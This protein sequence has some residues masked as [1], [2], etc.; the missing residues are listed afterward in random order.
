M[1]GEDSVPLI[2]NGGRNVITMSAVGPKSLARSVTLE[3]VVAVGVPYID[4]QR[5][6]PQEPE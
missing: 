5:V 2:D 1:T 3:T 6:P 4:A